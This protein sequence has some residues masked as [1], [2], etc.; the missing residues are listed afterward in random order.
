[1]LEEVRAGHETND[2]VS[3]Q[4]MRE[5]R[6]FASDRDLEVGSRAIERL[7]VKGAQCCCGLIA[8]TRGA[9]VVLMEVKQQTVV[10]RLLS[11]RTQPTF[12][13]ALRNWYL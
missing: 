5:P 13:P 8:S 10:R 6:G 7:V 3:A 12:W 4:H 2:L 9:I 1:M 11:S